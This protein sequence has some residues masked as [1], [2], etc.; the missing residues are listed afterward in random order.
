MKN[1][2]IITLVLTALLLNSCHTSKKAT[3]AESNMVVFC[4]SMTYNSQ[5]VNNISTDYYTIDTLF[6][7][8]NCLNIWVSYGGGCGDADFTLY[9]TNRVMESMPPK[10]SLLLQLTDNDPCR[11][12]VRQ[13]LF[14]N[15]SF[16]EEYAN[17]DGIL[18]KLSGK[19]ES[20]LYKK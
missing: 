16:F 13:K 8:D 19:G 5:P 2:S 4:E 7:V 6:I 15:L 14:Y 9:Y 17:R 20:V 11:A 1:I 10:T 18:L 3:D 12:I